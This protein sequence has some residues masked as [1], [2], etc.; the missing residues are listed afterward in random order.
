MKSDLNGQRKENQSPNWDLWSRVT[1]NGY[2]T[3]KAFQ[4]SVWNY[5]LGSRPTLGLCMC[6]AKHAEWL[7]A[8]QRS[9]RG[10]EVP[11]ATLWTIRHPKMSIL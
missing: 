4:K 2:T 8:D 6:N 11:W 9:Q 5:S 7:R 1:K 3:E 10:V